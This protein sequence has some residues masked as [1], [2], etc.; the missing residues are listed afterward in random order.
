M[1]LGMGK[2]W[3]R[4]IRLASG[5]FLFVFVTTHFLNHSLGNISLDAMEAGRE[6]FIAVWRNWPMTILLYGAMLLHVLMALWAI[7]QRRTLRMSAPE[8]FQVLLAAAI[9]FLLPAHILA[10]RG[11]HEIFGVNDSY[12]YE[13]TAIWVWLPQNTWI[14]TAA[15]LAVWS[16]GCIGLHQWLRLRQWYA[17]ARIWLF[18]A[19]ILLPGLALSG[20]AGVGKQIALW[21][22]DEAWREDA[23][24]SFRIG[25]N[26]KALV[27]FV[28]GTMDYVIA[29]TIVVVVL[30]LIG[31]W[32]RGLWARRGARITISYPDGMQTAVEPGL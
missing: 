10:T 21:F 9:P 5:L 8:A 30:L 12:L 20:F 18:F 13:I 1:V 3:A 4:K 23:F 16:H 32:L 17:R 19:A 27:D 2:G 7:W 14:L 31:R 25:D 11:A 28:Y 22:R 15:L 29:G 24:A 6:V 26:Q